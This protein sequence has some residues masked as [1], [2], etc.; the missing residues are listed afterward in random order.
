MT[1]S[2]RR[3]GGPTLQDVAERAGVGLMTASRA[4]S[5]AGNVSED[6][7]RRVQEAAASLGYRLNENARSLRP[8]QRTRLVGVVVTNTAN[9]YYAQLQV[10]IEEYLSPRHIRTLV[11]SSGDSPER[12]RQLVADFVGWN[13]GGLIVVPSGAEHDHLDRLQVPVVLASRRIPGAELDTVLIDDL[14]GARAAVRVL[15]DAGHH[16]IAFLGLGMSVSTGERRLEG[17]RRALH[18]AGIEPN[19]SLIRVG[20]SSSTPLDAARGLLGRREPP[21]AVFTANNRNTIALLHALRERDDL[22][23]PRI[24]GFDNFDTA[25]LMPVR[26]SLVDHDP[27]ELG[28][29]AAE[30]LVWRLDGAT[31]DPAVVELPIRLIP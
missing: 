1:R 16:R 10:G 8:G 3:S 9:P 17:F 30:L 5:N 14:A 21:T 31:D 11:G 13:V 20:P 27:V 22:D 15:T 2:G 7:M 26:L 6:K 25:D 4:L 29:R 18:E 12:E 23:P 28:R 19:D 24:A